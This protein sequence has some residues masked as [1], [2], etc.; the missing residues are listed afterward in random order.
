[1]PIYVN[2]ASTL[3]VQAS[4]YDDTGSLVVPA[5]VRYLIRDDSNDRLIRDWTALPTASTVDIQVAA[6]DNNLMDGTRRQKRFE[7]R[8]LTVQANTD[9]NSQCTDEIEYWVRN[10]AGIDN[11]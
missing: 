4:F 2:E 11:D 1:M 8:V 3:T 9:Q 6:S 10:L 5:T 7:K